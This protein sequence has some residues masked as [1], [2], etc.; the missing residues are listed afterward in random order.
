MSRSWSFVAVAALAGCSGP[1]ALDA[2]P[3][4]LAVRSTGVQTGLIG[5]P[6]NDPPAVRLLDADGKPIQGAAV[7]FTVTSGGGS[8]TGGVV[9]TGSDGVATVGGWTIAAGAN[10][11][12]ASIPAPFRVDPV[13]FAASGVGPAYQIDLEFLTSMTPSRQAAF[14]SAAARWQRLVYGDVPDLNISPPIPPDICYSGQP[15][16]GGLIDDIRI[17]VILDS[18]DGPGTILG[19]SSPCFIRSAG[20]LPVH[21]VMIFDTAD[22]AILEAQGLFDEVILHEMGH[23]LGFGTIWRP[24]YLSL[25]SGGGGSDPAFVGPLARTAFDRIGGIAYTG[26][27]KVPVENTGGPGTADAHW[28]E[29]VFGNELLTGYLDLGANPLSIVTVAS[30]GDEAYL[31]NYGA[32]DAYSHAF[33]VAPVPGAPAGLTAKIA[34]GND[35]LRVPIHTVDGRGRVTGVFRQ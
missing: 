27:L 14:D 12:T 31:V 20:K 1:D 34:L 15:A 28:R 4:A 10:G 22:V 35:V 32:A 3:A 19:Q 25:L 16:I 9:T 18:I 17:H 8:V 7:T 2:W 33:S 26:G 29:S 24:V 6:V 13:P 5:Y 23:V 11:L 21:G 30:M